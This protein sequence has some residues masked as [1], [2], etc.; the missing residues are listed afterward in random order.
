MTFEIRR[1]TTVAEV[2]DCVDLYLAFNDFSF[3]P[4]NRIKAI[5]ELAHAVRMNKF[6]LMAEF[7]GKL[8]G[9]IYARDAHISH[10]ENKALQQYYYASNLTGIRA[11]QLLTT[12]HQR[13]FDYAEEQGYEIVLSAGSH[14]DTTNVLPRVLSKNGWDTRGYL[15]VKKTKFYRDI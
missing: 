9:W 4:A 6:V 11:V 7:D 8:V 1:P 13:M 2:T 5:R 3:M 10:I 14:M 15:A 12:L